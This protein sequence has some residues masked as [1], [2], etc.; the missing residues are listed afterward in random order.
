MSRSD[1]AR[2]SNPVRG[3]GH[4]EPAGMR[5]AA[6]RR[7]GSGAIQPGVKSVQVGLRV[8]AALA[9]AYRPM[10]LSELAKAVAMP[11]A[12]VHRYLASLS[13]AGIV[14]QE[15]PGGRYG[16]GPLA[17]TLGLSAL[18]QLDHVRVAGAAMAALRDRTE[19]TGLVAVW[20]SA[21]PTIVRWEECRRPVAVNMRVG[22][23]LRLLDSA[24]G[25]VFVAFLPRHVT[26]G[27]LASEMRGRD[28]AQVEERLAEVRARKMARVRG[29]QM[30]SIHALSAPV[31]D[32]TGALV[33]VMT[34]LG[35]ETHFDATWDGP[36]AAA[37]RDAAGEASARL[38]AAIP[39]APASS[40]RPP[41][42]GHPHMT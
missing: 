18:H 13:R 11:S 14:E 7:A 17:L 16:L 28:A 24:T 15:G 36:L 30:A 34:L 37:L 35:P 33:A 9:A 2:V 23:V 27:L 31:F 41:G 19:Q 29:Q 22:S 38:G 4:G 3:S 21:G 1:E 20:G 12:K 40:A 25:L 32:H 39:D 5:A 26:E 6:T 42:A 8:L 10:M